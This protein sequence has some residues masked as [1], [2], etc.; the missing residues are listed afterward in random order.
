MACTQST[1]VHM[2]AGGY[3]ILVRGCNFGR[4]Y[5]HGITKNRK[6]VID[7]LMKMF[8]RSSFGISELCFDR[9]YSYTNEVKYT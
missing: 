3:V 2:I 6:C 5:V 8:L 4:R 7:E 1:V 9:L